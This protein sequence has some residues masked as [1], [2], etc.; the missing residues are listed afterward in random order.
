MDALAELEK[1]RRQALRPAKSRRG[2]GPSA[3]QARGTLDVSLPAEDLHR[4]SNARIMLRLEDTA[5]EPVGEAQSLQVS[6]NPD[7]GALKLLFEI[8][9]RVRE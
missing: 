9:L 8:E 1:L 3:R 2:E 6:I 5:G 4:L 7:E